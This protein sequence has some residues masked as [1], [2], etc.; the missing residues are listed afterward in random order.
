MPV[1]SIQLFLSVHT[2]KRNRIP[3]RFHALGYALK[4]PPD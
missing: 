2:D 3:E 4:T 1:L